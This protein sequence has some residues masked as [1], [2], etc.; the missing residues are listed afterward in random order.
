MPPFLRTASPFTL[1]LSSLLALPFAAIGT[2]FAYRAMWTIVSA[3]TMQAWPTVPATLQRVEL[4]TETRGSARATASYTYS[5]NGQQFTGKR[6]SLYGADNL[7]SF[8]Q[9]ATDELRGFLARKAPYPAHVNP[10]DPSESILMPVVRWEVVAFNLVFVVVFGGAGWGILIS[11]LFVWIRIRAQ[12]ALAAQYPSEP[13]RWRPD[14]AANRIKSSESST[15]VGA[16]CFTLFW[17]ACAWPMVFAVPG[18]LRAGEYMGLLFLVFPALGVA[19]AFWAAISVARAR[20]F[21]ATY[22]V[23]NTFP[24]RPGEQLSGC[25][26][27]PAAL[28]N[29]KEAKL[30]LRCE[31]NYKTA[32]GDGKTGTKTVTVWETEATSEVL[33]GQSSTGE[34]LLKVDFPVPDSFGDSAS[35][36]NGEYFTWQLT[37]NATLKGADFEAEF[38]VPVFYRDYNDR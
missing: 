25:V 17:N 30:A 10:K 29:A 27:A 12:R 9:T 23:L 19:L 33:R 32:G 11:S 26:Y 18:K 36:S 1:A 22:L 37:A 21:G 38:E 2:V 3:L 14:W 34:A 8:P 4:V 20:R 24:A 6:V 31:R 16:V 7:G 15:A 13:W 5:V 28:E 35:E